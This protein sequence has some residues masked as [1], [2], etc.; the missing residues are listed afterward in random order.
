[1]GS[2]ISSYEINEPTFVSETK[3]NL[4]IGKTLICPSGTPDMPDKCFDMD[5]IYKL[6][7]RQQEL[8]VINK[9]SASDLMQAM[10]EGYGH[11]S[12]AYTQLQWELNQA[13]KYADE[14]KGIVYL[15]VAPKLLQ[16]KG[17]IRPANP[18]GSEDQR[19]A[20]LAI[21]KTYLALCD[22]QAMIEAAVEFLHHKMKGFEQ[23]FQATKKVYDNLN[24]SIGYNR[25]EFSAQPD[26]E[27]AIGKP[28]Y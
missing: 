21:D 28:K 24:N 6:E 1:M 15:E 25:S 5:D 11:A 27:L 19:K 2:L 12:R 10:I 18:S 17:L 22:R 7:A 16:D 26:Q 14:R 23:T 13:K 3:L 9:N 8:S 20:V 4:S